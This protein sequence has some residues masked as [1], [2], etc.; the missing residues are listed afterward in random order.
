VVDKVVDL[1]IRID[2]DGV[3][4]D[5]HATDAIRGVIGIEE[6]EEMLAIKVEQVEANIIRVEV[7]ENDIET[8]G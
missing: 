6:R 1:T 7:L 8:F 3:F 5:I 2:I 4:M